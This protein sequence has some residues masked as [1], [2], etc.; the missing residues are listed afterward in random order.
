MPNSIKAELETG[1]DEYRTKMKSFRL[2][3]ITIQVAL[4]LLVP[5]EAQITC[6]SQSVLSLLKVL[7]KPADI[8]LLTCKPTLQL[9]LLSNITSDYFGG[10]H[11]PTTTELGGQETDFIILDLTCPTA[12]LVQALQFSHFNRVYSRWLI[13]DSAHPLGAINEPSLAAVI[14]ASPIAQSSEIFYFTENKH[15]GDLQIK[16]VYKRLKVNEDILIE[17]YGTFVNQTADLFQNNRIIQATSIRRKDLNGSVLELAFVAQYPDTLNHLYDFVDPEVDAVSK[18]AL[19]LTLVIL[20]FINAVPELVVSTFWGQAYPEN[21]NW[22]GMLGDLDAGHSEFAATPAI[23]SSSRLPACDYL[24]YSVK[25]GTQ[26]VF[27]APKLSYTTNVFLLPFDRTVWGCA[28]LLILSVM[29]LLMAATWSEW[30]VLVPAKAMQP[31]REMLPVQFSDI[32]FLI[33]GSILVQG[34]PASPRSTAGRIATI[35]CL[36]FIVCLYVSYSAFIVALLQSPSNNIRTIK[37]LFDSNMQVGNENTAYSRFWVQVSGVYFV[38][39]VKASN[40]KKY[41]AHAPNNFI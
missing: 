10:P 29:G 6:L 33:V 31:S 1:V 19:R 18:N 23:V 5:S 7:N 9:E 41:Q 25:T 26:I 4:Y 20:E 8:S 38:F 37:D 12:Q 16:Q 28:V 22:T 3:L 39:H 40:R 34:S 21:K 2:L 13:V 14:S 32:C 17:N 27:R 36:I 15:N 24:S 35:F 30:H 11:R